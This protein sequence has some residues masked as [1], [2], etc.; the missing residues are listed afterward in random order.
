MDAASFIDVD[1]DKWTFY[2]MYVS[3]LCNHVAI[4]TVVIYHKGTVRFLN[5]KGCVISSGRGKEGGGRGR[6]G[7]GGGR[8][9]AE[10]E[11]ERGKDGGNKEIGKKS[12]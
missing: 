10:E 2:L 12:K 8:D 9:K 7:R 4:L 3:M 5:D 11:G 6:R 1:D